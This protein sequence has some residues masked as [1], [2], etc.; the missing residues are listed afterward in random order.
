MSLSIEISKRRILEVLKLEMNDVL[1]EVVLDICMRHNLDYMEECRVLNLL[2]C[3]GVG[4]GDG[5]DL[6]LS[7]S[8]SLL[9]DKSKKVYRGR[10]P[11]PY[12]GER[13]IGC[14]NGLKYTEGLMTQ[15]R[16]SIKE[17]EE[18]CKTCKN[19]AEKNSN[20]KPTYGRIEDRMKVGIMEYVAPNGERPLKYSEIMKKYKFTKEQVLEE[21]SIMNIKIA[22]CHLEEVEEVSVSVKK[23]SRRG[24]PRSENKKEPIEKKSSTSSSSSSKPQRGRPKKESKVI[25]LGG[26][27]L[28]AA[29][30]ANQCETVVVEKEVKKVAEKVVEKVAEKEVEKEVKKA[31][32]VVEKVAEK[33]VEEEAEEE[34][35]NV[36]RINYEGQKYLKSID[37]GI[38]Y[39]EST[40][41]QVGEWN[42]KTNKIDF[43][44]DEEEEEEEYE[45]E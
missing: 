36:T 44:K 23:E 15:C 11:L 20:G 33:E 45:E 5:V 43:Y 19:Q 30:I 26:D 34:E 2:E 29:L 12:N 39:D 17:V 31:E 7:L 18:Y 32:N 3:G 42:F 9:I 21:A 27:D 22:E 13:M 14:C 38:I 40:Q 41:E 24:R 8:S 10:F 28:F 1:K 6:S 16:V 37:T 4:V 35:I 25:E